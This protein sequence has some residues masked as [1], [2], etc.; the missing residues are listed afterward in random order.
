ME[1]QAYFFLLITISVFLTS[2][3]MKQQLH[4]FPKEA[5]RMIISES[6]DCD[7]ITFVES[8]KPV[9]IF[10]KGIIARR[11]TE[12]LLEFKDGTE[13]SYSLIKGALYMD[14]DWDPLMFSGSA[15]VIVDFINGRTL[16]ASRSNPTLNAVEQTAELFNPFDGKTYFLFAKF[17]GDSISL[18][19]SLTTGASGKGVGY[20]EYAYAANIY[21]TIYEMKVLRKWESVS[22]NLEENGEKIR[23]QYPDGAYIVISDDKGGKIRIFQ[24]AT[25]GKYLGMNAFTGY[26]SI[27]YFP[28][29]IGSDIK[30]DVFLFFYA[31]EFSKDFVDDIKILPDCL[32]YSK[33]RYEEE[34][35]FN[36]VMR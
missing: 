16:R 30:R 5:S 31:S 3:V 12:G 26:K 33:D 9:T 24:G 2:C 15:G 22:E 14:K 8:L 34:C 21:G 20:L 27:V 28:R 19:I 1:K 36:I 6:C 29:G 10:D 18:D 23:H 35:D 32:T 25:T 11:K 4:S 17:D 7:T 13:Q